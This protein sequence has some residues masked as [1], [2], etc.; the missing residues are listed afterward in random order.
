MYIKN[1]SV[2]FPTHK[3]YV[4]AEGASRNVLRQEGTDER[5]ESPC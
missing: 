3:S 2:K 1:V 4:I 5:E